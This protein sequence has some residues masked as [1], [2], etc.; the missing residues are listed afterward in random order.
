MLQGRAPRGKGHGTH[1]ARDVRRV[2]KA[3]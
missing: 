1:P 2:R 3:V